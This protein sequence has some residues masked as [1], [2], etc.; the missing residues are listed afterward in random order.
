MSKELLIS[1]EETSKA[2]LELT[3]KGFL[4]TDSVYNK[5]QKMDLSNN[6][7]LLYQGPAQNL[8]KN[9]ITIGPFPLD[10]DDYRHFRKQGLPKD[11]LY[12]YLAFK[13]LMYEKTGTT[14]GEFEFS[15]EDESMAV[16]SGFIE[17]CFDVDHPYFTEFYVWFY[18]RLES[19]SYFSKSSVSDF[20]NIDNKWWNISIELNNT[21]LHLNLP[22]D[23]HFIFIPSI[24]IGD[25]SKYLPIYFTDII[26]QI[27]YKK[28]R[29]STFS[30]FKNKKE[31]TDLIST[32]FVDKKSLEKDYSPDRELIIKELLNY[33]N[34]TYPV[35]EQSTYDLLIKIGI[36][37]LEYEGLEVR[38][39]LSDG[40]HVKLPEEVLK[41][42][43]TWTNKI[44]NYLETGSIL[45]SY[46]NIK[47]LF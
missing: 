21:N 16:L 3:Q 38:Y 11:A 30:S 35:D 8:D 4:F 33:N 13:K 40:S 17:K 19:K 27:Y 7:R 25:W 36:I 26:T 28:S 18:P 23:E 32:I 37:V 9:I 29:G 14:E 43:S 20:T 1:K 6:F 41:F 47:E 12:L 42:P 5:D 34:L 15:I 31:L 46:L 45:L 22:S 39:Q 44:N 24:I 2:Q 10:I